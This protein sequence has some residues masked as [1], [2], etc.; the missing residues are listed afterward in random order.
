MNNFGFFGLNLGKL[1][2]HV[3]Y[4]GF[5]NVEGIA[6]TWVEV[7]VSQVE[8]GGAGWSWMELGGDRWNWVEV[9]EWFSNTLFKLVLLK[10][11][12]NSQFF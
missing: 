2:N 9:G 12:K 5:N 7:E 10:T 4:F 11:L 1:P 6:E 3:Q 8:V